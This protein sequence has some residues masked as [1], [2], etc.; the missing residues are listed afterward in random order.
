[1]TKFVC[2]CKIDIWGEMMNQLN[3]FLEHI[4]EACTQSGVDFPEMLTEAR[5]MGY[6]G[7]EC[8]LWRLDDRK[9]LEV[10]DGCGIKAASVYGHYD[11]AHDTPEIT[12]EKASRHLESAAYFRADK[13]LVIPGFFRPE[14][15]RD[16][17]FARTCEHL[18]VICA[19]A[20]KY[21]ITVTVEDFDDVNSPCCNTAGLERL[22]CSSEGLRWTFDIGNFAYVCE[23]P[24]KA[25][26]RLGKYL[27]H[28]HIKDRSRDV[29]RAFP[30]GSNV[31]ADVSGNMMYPC[32]CGEGYVGAEQL[33]KQLISDGYT[34]D[35]SAEHFGAVNQ[36]EY[37]RRSSANILKWIG[38][39]K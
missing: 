37:M 22:L 1:M 28:V 33:V 23:E 20:K 29:S 24:A 14:D 10:L 30:D 15:D 21:G 6:T 2:C 25:Y 19:L 18:S 27:S 34:G 11:L 3:I 39:C 32:E 4:Y 13:I 8:D 5:T 26:A 17:F 35:F 38:E 16:V 36:R 7:L 9:L 31:K 12:L